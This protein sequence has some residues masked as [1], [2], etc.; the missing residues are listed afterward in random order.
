MTIVMATRNGGA[1]IDEQL[2]SFAAQD[3]Q[4][5]SLLVSDDGSEDDTCV[6]IS[7]FAQANPRSDIAIIEGPRNGA[8]ANFL[9]ALSYC[10]AQEGPGYFAF[11]DQD[12]VWLPHKLSVALSKLAVHREDHGDARPAVYASRILFADTALQRTRPSPRP[13]R[14]ADFG[15]ALVQNILCGS[16]IVLNP[17]ASA[18]VHRGVRAALAAGVPFHDWWIYQVLSGAG[19]DIILDDQPGL[20]YRQHDQNLLGARSGLKAHLSRLRMIRSHLYRDW[21][22]ANLSALAD[23]TD[24]LTPEARDLSDQFASWRRSS[25]GQRAQLSELGI[26]RQT[27]IGDHIMAGL[28]RFGLL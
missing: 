1:F 8:A 9:S 17:A 14:P 2:A 4:G 18:L 5:W 10:V 11:S 20:L 23:L 21:I 16:T 22:S 15:N 28:G 26:Y 19:A 7:R 12:D 25:P 13:T 3:H 24:L 27:A 6:R